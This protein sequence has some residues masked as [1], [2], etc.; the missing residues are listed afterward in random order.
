M[1]AAYSTQVTMVK[2]EVLNY[3][4]NSENI[5]NKE[6]YDKSYLHEFIIKCHC[7][8]IMNNKVNN[9][10]EICQSNAIV[11]SWFIFK[12]ISVAG[13]INRFTISLLRFSAIGRY[14]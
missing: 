6:Y 3:A 8:H 13:Y 12:Y 4:V 5:I 1:Y 14:L 7:G 9:G 10:I 2:S 11:E